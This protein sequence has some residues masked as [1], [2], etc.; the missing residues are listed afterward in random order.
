MMKLLNQFE[1]VARATPLAR[2]D[3][4]STSAAEILRQLVGFDWRDHY[5]RMVQ[6]TGPQ[7]I[8]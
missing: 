8:P 3:E 1:H 2:R 4:L 6:G 7:P 5:S